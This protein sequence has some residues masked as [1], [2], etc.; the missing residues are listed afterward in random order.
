MDLKVLSS[1]NYI[2]WLVASAVFFAVG[3]FFSKKFA[4]D[5]KICYVVLILAA[6]CIGTL[7]WLPA[8]LQK[9]QL[10][11]VG[12]MWSVLSLLVTVSIGLLIFKESLSLIGIIGV[13][14]AFVSII[15]LSLA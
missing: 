11:I 4:L 1:V 12:T 10:S 14:L 13:L 2:I 15:L 9:N 8:I 6:Y 5:P 7:F 3:E